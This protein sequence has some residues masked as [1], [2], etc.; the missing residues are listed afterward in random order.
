MG[1]PFYGR[2]WKNVGDPIFEND[3]MWRIATPVNG[4]YEGGFEPWKKI[5]SDWLTNKDYNFIMHEK[6]KTPFAWNDK[7]KT[8][9]GYENP[10]SLKYK[11][12]YAEDNNLGGLMIWALDQDDEENSMLLI[13]NKA[14]LCK[15]T[16][17][18][19]V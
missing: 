16:E 9:L 18:K 1:V 3:G 2:Y 13:L 6:S 8:F 15:I 14:Q 11:V 5:K 17:P 4:K 19:K 7:T 10:E 12:Q